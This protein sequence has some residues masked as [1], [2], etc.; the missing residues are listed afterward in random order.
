LEQ[1]RETANWEEMQQNFVITF[2]FEHESPEIDTTL[3][4]VRDKIF[5]EPEVEIVTTYQNQKR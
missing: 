2:S 4:V 5:E 1:C 3:K